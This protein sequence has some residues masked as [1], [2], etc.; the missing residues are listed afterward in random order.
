MQQHSAAPAAL[1]RGQA[2]ALTDGAVMQQRIGD[3]ADR[4]ARKGGS[5]GNL[6]AGEGS[7]FA[8][9]GKHQ[10]T[11]DMSQRPLVNMV[12]LCEEQRPLWRL[13]GVACPG[14]RRH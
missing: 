14:Q 10:R 6:D 13:L 4:R 7:V 9:T 2:L 11:V 5:L 8:D 1:R 3:G 12:Y